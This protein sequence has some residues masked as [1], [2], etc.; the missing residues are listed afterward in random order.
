VDVEGLVGAGVGAGREV[1]LSDARVLEVRAGDPGSGGAGMVEHPLQVMEVGHTEG[2]GAGGGGRRGERE[3][4]GGGELN[5]SGHGWDWWLLLGVLGLSGACWVRRE[6]SVDPSSYRCGVARVGFVTGFR[7]C[8]VAGSVA[9]VSLFR[10][11]TS[12]VC[13]PVGRPI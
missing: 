5:G 7:M 1:V 8:L 2:E 10:W 4:G 13:H 3:Q 6:L 9:R 12:W 11:K